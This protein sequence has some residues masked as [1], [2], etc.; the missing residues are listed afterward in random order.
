MRAPSAAAIPDTR[1]ASEAPE[2]AMMTGSNCDCLICRLETILVAEVG[3]DRANDGPGVCVDSWGLFSGFAAPLDLVREL[4]AHDHGRD[5][6]SADRVLSELLKRNS[7]APPPSLWQKVLLLVFIPTIHRTTSQ[8]AAVFPSLARDDTSQHVLCVLLQFL[9]S[10]ELETRH[11]HIAFT[12]SRKL[13]RQAFR[14]AIRESRGA[15]GEFGPNPAVYDE[16]PAGDEPRYAGILLGQFL[17]DCE[18]RACLSG[19]ER[20]LL[21]R[22]KIEGATYRELA[23]RNGLGAEGVR[24]RIRRLLNRL[25]SLAREARTERPSEQIELFPR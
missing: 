9:R 16:E 11:T 15:P 4:H 20:D 3:N 2:R 23:G 21:V 14:W 6:S 13:R 24:H 5:S 17:D 25:R 1:A 12:I 18:R 19:E 10:P 7:K 22:F 8:I